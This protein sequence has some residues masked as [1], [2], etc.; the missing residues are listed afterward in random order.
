MYDPDSPT[1]VLVP[2]MLPVTTWEQNVRHLMGGPTWDRMRRH[3]Y[4]ATGFRCGICGQGGPLEAH[5]SWTLANET[6]VQQ[7]TG[8][9]AHC[10]LCHKAKH[11]GVAKRLGIWPDVCAQLRLVNNWSQSDLEAAV[12]EA[13]EVWEQRCDWPWTVDLSWLQ[14]QGYLYV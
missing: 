4:R 2:E 11:M 7:L 14:D 9:M 10:P 6:C 1:P 3:A 12:Q 13:R 5:E 8:I